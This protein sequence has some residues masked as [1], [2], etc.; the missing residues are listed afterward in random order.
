MAVGGGCES[1]IEKLL[2]NVVGPVAVGYYR[3][4]RIQL[5]VRMRIQETLQPDSKKGGF[6]DEGLQ[7]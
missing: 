4:I 3:M 1:K 5:N 6:L 7:L 2:A